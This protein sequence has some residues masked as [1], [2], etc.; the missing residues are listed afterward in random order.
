[1][2]PDQLR[3]KDLKENA[4]MR[5]TE[6]EHF[7]R[8]W[9]SSLVQP[10]KDSHAAYLAIHAALRERIEAG[11]S[12]E[13]GPIS[14]EWADSI[15]ALERLEKCIHSAEDRMASLT[16]HPTRPKAGQPSRPGAGR[17]P[18]DTAEPVEVQE[19][20]MPKPEV[21]VPRGTKETP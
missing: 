2:S 6:L 3:D 17:K 1:M 5:R 19:I 4:L 9:K 13:S 15:Q 8:T 11:V 18:G 21:D 16:L 10:L 7:T 12:R 14:S 20:A